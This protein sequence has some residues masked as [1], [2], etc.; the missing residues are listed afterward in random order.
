MGN[1]K[2]PYDRY[3]YCPKCYAHYLDALAKYP[4]TDLDAHFEK[5][6]EERQEREWKSKMERAASCVCGAYQII[7]HV[8]PVQV[9]DCVCGA[10]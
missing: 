8:D 4:D 1:Q 5:E 10:G 7:G 9:A 2:N 6:E 3:Y